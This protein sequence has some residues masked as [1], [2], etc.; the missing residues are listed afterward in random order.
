MSQRSVM[1]KDES[2]F[3]FPHLPPFPKNVS[4]APLLRVKLSKLL[5]GDQAEIDRLF[6]A[7]RELGFFYLDVR[8]ESAGE[9]LV[10]YARGLFGEGKKIFDLPVEEKVTYDLGSRGS[11]F[12][13]K[14]YGAGTVDASGTKDRN[15]F[16][17]Y[18]S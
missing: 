5:S 18:S 10:G 3:D 13:Y 15:E 4:I 11:H 6:K 1:I 14:G 2:E 16:Y 17:N 7:S 8:G 12:G 9:E